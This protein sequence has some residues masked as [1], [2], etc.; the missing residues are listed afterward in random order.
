MDPIDL[1]RIR[2]LKAKADAAGRRWLMMYRERDCLENSDKR[3]QM[4]QA[5]VE[6]QDAC[7]EFLFLLRSTQRRQEK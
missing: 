6:Y 3:A 5:R 7:A 2:D 4:L 1:K